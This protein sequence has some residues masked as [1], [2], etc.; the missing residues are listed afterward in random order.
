MFDYEF[1]GIQE[2]EIQ[3]RIMLISLKNVL[4]GVMMMNGCMGLLSVYTPVYSACAMQV[5]FAHF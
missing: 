5:G 1:S 3:E 4:S 2:S